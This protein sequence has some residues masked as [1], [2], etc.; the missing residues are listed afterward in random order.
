[1]SSNHEM[2]VE[3]EYEQWCE[4]VEEQREQQEA[5]YDLYLDDCAKMGEIGMDFEEWESML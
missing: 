1:M 2:H 3:Y 4:Y 5:R